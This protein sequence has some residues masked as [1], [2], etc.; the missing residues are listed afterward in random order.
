MDRPVSPSLQAHLAARG[1]ELESTNCVKWSKTNPRHPRNWSVWRKTFDFGLLIFLDFFTTVISTAGTFSSHSASHKL[2]IGKSLSLFSFVTTYMIAQAIGGVFFPPYSESFG[3]KKLFVTST[4]L[5]CVS[6]I[7]IGN[8]NHIGAVIA[9]RFLSGLSSALPTVVIAGSAEDM[10]DS[11]RRIWMLYAWAVAA[12]VGICIGPIFGTAV[13]T[14]IGWHWVFHISA[15]VSALCTILL[16]FIKESR[17]SQVLSNELARLHNET[18]NQSLHIDNPDHAPDLQTFARVAMFRPLQLFFTEPIVFVS[19]ILGA[20]VFGLLYL[21]T[22]AIPIVYESFGFTPFQSSLA[23][24]PIII[25]F[26]S[27]V[28][29]RLYDQHLY[30]TKLRNNKPFQPEQ[31][32]IGFVIGAPALAVGL[33]WFAWT[34][35]PRVVHVPWVVSMLSLFLVGY[36]TNEFDCTLAGYLADSYTI[37]AAS[38][39]APTAFLRSLCCATFPL[40]TRGMY[41]ELDANVASSVLAAVATVFCFAPALF[42]S[43]GRRL[44]ERSAFAKISLEANRVNDLDREGS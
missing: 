18:N 34:V 25:G 37:F 36:A 41:A 30:T 13:V 39:F 27:G 7:M 22:E 6:S 15:I 4:A 16:L 19:S 35:P 10:F 26:F 24:L 38:A 9:G 42:I 28:G 20:V 11:G 12:N 23:F 31:K 33:W 8:L 3:R 32:L 1:F 21:F 43:R 2:H 5:Y 44:R 29:T 14:S 17:P 40:F